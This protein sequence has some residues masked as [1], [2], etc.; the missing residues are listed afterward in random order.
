MIRKFACVNPVIESFSLGLPQAVISYGT[1]SHLE[2]R[3]TSTMELFCKNSQRSKDVEYFHKKA[4]P[5]IYDCISN[6]P[7]IGKVL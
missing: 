7:S 5:Q 4:S 2:S 1:E 6:G 3:Q